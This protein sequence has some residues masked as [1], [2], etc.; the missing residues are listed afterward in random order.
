MYLFAAVIYPGAAVLFLLLTIAAYVWYKKKLRLFG[1]SDE[2]S[3]IITKLTVPRTNPKNPDAEPVCHMWVEYTVN[4]RTYKTYMHRKIS[5]ASYQE[6]QEVTVLYD[7]A[8]PS[9]AV[10]KDFDGAKEYWLILPIA[11]LCFFA[12]FSLLSIYTLKDLLDLSSRGETIYKIVFNFTLSAGIIA[13]MIAFRRTDVYRREKEK[14][15]K[16]MRASMLMAVM[17]IG[18]FMLDAVFDLVFYIIL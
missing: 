13:G 9:N 12:V 17:I 5:A 7:P 1:T 3:G 18:K 16:G 10:P 15:P 2:T 8:K 6:G 11:S 14:D 4:D